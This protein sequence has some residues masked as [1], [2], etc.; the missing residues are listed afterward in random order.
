MKTGY[1]MYVYFLA[2]ER[3]F[4]LGTLRETGATLAR[5]RRAVTASIT[6]ARSRARFSL[7]NGHT[8]ENERDTTRG[9]ASRATT[10]TT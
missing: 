1:A 7:S 9:T 3:N 4:R 10:D 6:N 2:C 5:Y 8:D